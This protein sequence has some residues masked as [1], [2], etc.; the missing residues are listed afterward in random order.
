MKVFFTFVCN[1]FAD[2]YQVVL[3]TMYCTELW[4]TSF[5]CTH[6]KRRL[7]TEKTLLFHSYLTISDEGSP[8]DVQV[9]TNTND[10]EEHSPTETQ[11]NFTLSGEKAQYSPAM[12][13]GLAPFS[14][15]VNP[16]MPPVGM[17]AEHSPDSLPLE[18]LKPLLRRQLEF[19]FSRYEVLE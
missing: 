3:H 12:V 5:P 19:Y 8:N 10:R 1:F 4:K 16:D 14:S 7:I 17:S 6:I 15:P 13:N 11:N 18:E 2:K 9:M